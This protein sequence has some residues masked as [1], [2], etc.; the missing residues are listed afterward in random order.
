[1][2]NRVFE[3]VALCA[4]IFATSA[5]LFGQPVSAEQKLVQ[6]KTI[7]DCSTDSLQAAIDAVNV[8]VPTI[9]TVEG[10]CTED[11][12]IT[13]DDLVIQGD[14][15]AGGTVDGT[16]T[17]IGARRVTITNMI[18]T[19]PGFGIFATD[20]A[21]VMVDDSDIVENHVDGILVENGAHANIIDSIISRNGQNAP[22]N[23]G[24]GVNVNDSGTARITKSTIADN[25]ADG[26][27]VFNDGFA[28]VEENTIVRNGLTGSSCGSGGCGVQVSRA[29]VRANGNIIRNNGYAAIGLYN[30]GVYRTGSYLSDELGNPD[31]Q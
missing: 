10:D 29:R 9:I 15:T 1:M 16:I 26:I 12:T 3:R 25:L 14:A 4:G 8:G 28:R 21:T 7:V 2:I 27:G 17:I 22:P 31:N 13:K 6:V 19:G 11:V 20:N 30:Q 18:V 23:F 24:L 5:W